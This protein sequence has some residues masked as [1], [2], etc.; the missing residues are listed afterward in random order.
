ML[1][2]PSSE[3]LLEQLWSGLPAEEHAAVLARLGAAEGR[4]KLPALK[5][6]ASG[7][8]SKLQKLG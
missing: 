7:L 8:A 4:E 6:R 3:L 2:P 5:A 1:L